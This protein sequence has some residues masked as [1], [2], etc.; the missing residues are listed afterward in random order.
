MTK[1]LIV[2][3]DGTTEKYRFDVTY[4]PADGVVQAMPLNCFAPY[5]ITVPSEYFMILCQDSDDVILTTCILLF[6]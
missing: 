6:N 3:P 4:F 1:L 5:R 2:I